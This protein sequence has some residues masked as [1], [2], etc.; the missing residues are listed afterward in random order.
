MRIV[1]IEDFWSH[2][3]WRACVRLHVMGVILR[4]AEIH[5]SHLIITSIHNVLW[6]DVTMGYSTGVTVLKCGQA[7]RSDICS[8]LLRISFAVFDTIIVRIK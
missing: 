1:A 5:E 7:L 2:E 8:H 4:E 6:F 3:V